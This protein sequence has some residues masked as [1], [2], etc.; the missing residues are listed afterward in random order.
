M[1]IS[2]VVELGD[3]NDLPFL[4]QCTI[5]QKWQMLMPLDPLWGKKEI[6]TR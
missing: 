5:F 3:P 1:S 6:S 2:L 4:F